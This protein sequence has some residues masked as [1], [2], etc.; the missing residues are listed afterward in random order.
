MIFTYGGE[1]NIRE[2]LVILPDDPA[3]IGNRN[4]S[5]KPMW[6]ILIFF[7]KTYLVRSGFGPGSGLE[8]LE[9]SNPNPVKSIKSQFK[10][11]KFFFKMSKFK[12]LIYT[13]S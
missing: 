8:S 3:E 2:N 12:A 10:L 13:I 1:G 7:C 9:I 6:L 11:K 5:E 4:S